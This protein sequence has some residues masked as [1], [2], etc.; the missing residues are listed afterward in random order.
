MLPL[1]RTRLAVSMLIY[2]NQLT[3]DL[4]EYLLQRCESCKPSHPALGKYFPVCQLSFE[5]RTV[6]CAVKALERVSDLLN[7]SSQKL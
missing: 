1:D 2:A 4:A 7:V 6:Y 3:L 5:A